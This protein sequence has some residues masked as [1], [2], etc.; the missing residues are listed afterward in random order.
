M[1]KKDHNVNQKPRL[2]SFGFP[3]STKNVFDVPNS[4]TNSV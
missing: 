2:A 4:L 1:D 3:K